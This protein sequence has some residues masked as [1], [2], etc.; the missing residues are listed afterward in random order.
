LN[1]CVKQ[2]FKLTDHQLR[3][4]LRKLRS[5][6][7]ENGT[8]KESIDLDSLTQD[9]LF[10]CPTHFHVN[11]RADRH[12]QAHG[13]VYFVGHLRA[14]VDRLWTL[15]LADNSATKIA[16]RQIW[17]QYTAAFNANTKLAKL[18]ENCPN[19]TINAQSKIAVQSRMITAVQQ[20]LVCSGN[21]KSTLDSIN[22]FRQWNTVAT[23]VEIQQV[24]AKL[25]DENPAKRKKN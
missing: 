11:A 1:E 3:G 20:G 13:C 17:E 4:F 6:W 5:L 24:L 12:V 16:T 19:G 21:S 23:P 25:E 15:K 10:I 8:E 7:E 18:I 22:R 9:H 2:G 14:R